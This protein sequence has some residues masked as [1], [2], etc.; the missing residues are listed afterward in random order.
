M[1]SI[2]DLGFGCAFA[3]GLTLL[4]SALVPAAASAAAVDRCRVPDAYFAAIKNLDRTER[5]VRSGK[6]VRVFIMGPMVG[7]NSPKPVFEA[8]LEH[9]LPGVDFQIT[10]SV[11]TGLAEDDFDWLRNVVARATP[12]LVIWQVGVRDAVA[13]SDRDD[14]QD[15]LDRAANWIDARGADLILV[16]PPFVPHVQHERIYVPYV[17]EIGELS[18]TENVPLIRRYAAMQHLNL[19][20]EKARTPAVAL[21]PCMPEI[22]AEAIGRA[23]AK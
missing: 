20:A 1:V 2:R 21:Q 13:A 22:M 9:R 8:A 16:D 11:S 15:V 3:A 19:A 10:Q 5:L 12:D 7:G 4:G 14:F 23:V 6:S 17:G 18:R